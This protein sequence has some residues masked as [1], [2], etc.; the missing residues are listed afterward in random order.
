MEDSEVMVSL[1]S[2]DDFEMKKWMQSIRDFHDCQVKEGPPQKATG[3]NG[4]KVTMD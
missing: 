3:S 1:C 4:M 2:S